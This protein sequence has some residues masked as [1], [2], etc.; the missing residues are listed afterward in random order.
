MSNYSDV[1]VRRLVLAVF[2]LTLTAALGADRAR[3]GF[4][5]APVRCG[6]DCDRDRTVA[7]NELVTGVN[8]VLGSIAVEQCSAVRLQCRRERDGGV[9]GRGGRPRPRRLS[10]ERCRAGRRGPDQRRPRRAV[11]RHHRLRPRRGRLCRGRVLHLRRCKGLRQRPAI[12]RRR[13]VDRRAGRDGGV[14][15]AHPRLPPDRPATVQRHGDR[16]VAQRQRRGR[17][18]ARLDHGAH[19]AHPRGYAWVGVS[20]QFVGVEGG[21]SVV[22]LQPHA[23]QDGGPGALR[24]AR[25]S[26]RQLLVRHLLAGRRRRSG[27]RR[28]STR[29][30]A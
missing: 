26:R 17:R 14:Q 5:G 25:P 24:L 13:P 10:V 8:I 12:E 21:G 30:A 4:A 7:V 11:P 18:R 9:P 16:R 23:A 28:S 20:A 29:S 1:A 19:R 27:S 3:A 2:A 15:D 6:G 22:G